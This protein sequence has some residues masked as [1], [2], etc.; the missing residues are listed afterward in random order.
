MGSTRKRRRSFLGYGVSLLAVLSATVL[1]ASF[2]ERVRDA[3]DRT[4]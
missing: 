1:L 4:T 3:A 2:V